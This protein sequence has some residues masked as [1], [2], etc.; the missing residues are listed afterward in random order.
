MTLTTS[1]MTTKPFS[2]LKE[3]R[4]KKYLLDHIKNAFG[5]VQPDV[6][7]GNGH[8]LKGDLFSVLEETVWAPHLPQP[9][10]FE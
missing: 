2:I 6:M 3:E 8:R 10:H 4:T 5:L 1:K 9:I 7:V